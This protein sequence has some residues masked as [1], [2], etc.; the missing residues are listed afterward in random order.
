MPLMNFIKIRAKKLY[1][2]I[3]DVFAYNR[4]A[5]RIN[6]RKIILGRMFLFET[7]SGDKVFCDMMKDLPLPINKKLVV[8]IL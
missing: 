4:G 6:H 8:F 1:A 5:G 3:S 2:R 7:T